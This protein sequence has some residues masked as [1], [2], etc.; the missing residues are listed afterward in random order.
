[1]IWKLIGLL[2][3]FLYFLGRRSAKAD[4]KVEELTDYVETRQ[5]M[6]E[7]GRMSDADAARMWLAERGKR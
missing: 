6:D 2:S 1:M 4:A 7:V 5:R 3:G